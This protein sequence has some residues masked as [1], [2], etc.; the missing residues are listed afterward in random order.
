[1]DQEGKPFLPVHSTEMGLAARA[2]QR[3]LGVQP[4]V[5]FGF[6]SECY[7][8]LVISPRKPTGDG[9]ILSFSRPFVQQ[10]AD[11]KNQAANRALHLLSMACVK[12]RDPSV[13]A[14]RALRQGG[15]QSRAGGFRC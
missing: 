5:F 7:Q 6:L 3:A 13:F 14:S 11:L 2:I 15:F 9:D 10:R 12:S 4:V 8:L 1:M